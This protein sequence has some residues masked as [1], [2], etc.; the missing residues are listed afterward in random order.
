MKGF[1]GPKKSNS[2]LLSREGTWGHAA[3]NQVQG[4]KAEKREAS[5]NPKGKVE[6]TQEWPALSSLR[7]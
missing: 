2:G 1:W 5:G 7:V 3:S 4:V 6:K